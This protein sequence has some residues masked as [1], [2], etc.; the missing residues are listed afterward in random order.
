MKEK[1]KTRK[2][3]GRIGVIVL[4]LAL[5]SSAA[6]NVYL[7]RRFGSSDAVWNIHFPDANSRETYDTIHHVSEAQ[8]IST[9]KGVKVGI[10]DWG[11][12]F[13]DH[14]ELYE[15]GKDFTSYEYHDEKYFPV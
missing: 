11:F 15:D 4:I 13:E 6:F 8:K 2:I 3:L 14:R 1:T 10:L 9:G 5:C 12:G 7:I